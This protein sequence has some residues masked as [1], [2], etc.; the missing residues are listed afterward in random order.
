MG[1][2]RRHDTDSGDDAR[3]RNTK[4]PRLNTSERNTTGR[5]T[6]GPKSTKPKSSNAKTE[7]PE[8]SK[9][10]SNSVAPATSRYSRRQ[11]LAL[12][13]PQ[14]GSDEEKEANRSK[15]TSGKDADKHNPP[16][17]VECS[18]PQE[19]LLP[20]MLPAFEAYLENY[21]SRTHIYGKHDEDYHKLVRDFQRTMTPLFQKYLH[22]RI[23]GMIESEAAP[24][25]KASQPKQRGSACDTLPEEQVPGGKKVPAG[26]QQVDQ[27][28][29]VL[30]LEY[31]LP[32]L[33]AVGSANVSPG[34][35]QIW[36]LRDG[37]PPNLLTKRTGTQRF[38]RMAFFAVSLSSRSAKHGG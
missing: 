23:T 28:G 30:G 32:C 10:K 24:E 38:W 4:R 8:T 26:A 7:G 18:F 13:P 36:K 14:A 37:E 19:E 11:L 20:A 17:D 33:D 3:G 6:T 35:I 29:N 21:E 34:S 9:A 31:Q 5:K 22:D 16:R 12:Q 1:R 25:G 15:P 27:P 2:A